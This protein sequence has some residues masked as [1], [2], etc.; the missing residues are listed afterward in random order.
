MMDRPCQNS[1]MAKKP[2]RIGTEHDFTVVAR[3]VV[4]RAIGERLDGSPLDDPD[5]GKHPRFKALGK[6]GGPKG[7]RARATALSPERRSQIAKKAAAARWRD[8]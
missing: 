8:K 1:G 7:G 2:T 3:R 6:A 4:E 5:A